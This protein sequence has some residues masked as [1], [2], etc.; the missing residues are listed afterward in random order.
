MKKPLVLHITPHLPG[1]L[2]RILLSTLKFSKSENAKFEHEIIITDE[3]HLTESSL[4]TFSKYFDCLHIGKSENF[5]KEKMNNA[6]IVQ[7]EWW[8]H[9]LVYK[10]LTCFSFPPTRMILCSHVNGLSRPSIVTENVVDFSDIFLSATKATRK[11]PLFQSKK[12]D[13]HR[14]K[15]R[16][17][18]YPVDFERFGNIKLKKHDGFNVGY[19]GTLDYSKMYKNYLSMSANINISKIKFIVCGDGFDEEKIKLEAKKYPAEKFQFLGFSENIKT[20][21]ENLDVFGY[22]LNPNHYGSGEQ[23]INEAMYA[24]LPVVAFSNPAEQEII[25]HN[26]TGILVDDEQSYVDAIKNLHSNP[27]ERSRLGKNAHKHIIEKLNT[28]QCFQKLELVYK[29]IM[30]LNKKSRTFNT[31]IKNSNASKSDL[32]AR[33]FI[34]SL[35][36][37]G[38]EFFQSYKRSGEKTN[39][40]IN[41]IIKEAEIGMKVVTKGSIFQYLYFFPNDAL[42]NFWVGLISLADKNVLKYRH[43]SIPKTTKECFEKA[44]SIDKKNNEFQFYLKKC[45]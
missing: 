45:S 6:D 9:P 12:N 2:G 13:Q 15:L 24:G 41:E 38:K 42:L 36:I 11:H 26:D 30:D 35:G 3:K 39:N 29:E 23:A 22:P 28:L 40:D 17:V 20:I 43:A 7:I 44:A 32:G 16:Y 10:F 5:I 25:T 31:T 14:K 27:A 1:G 18:T 4:K 37:Q 8:N 34:E 21:L 33:L 19:V